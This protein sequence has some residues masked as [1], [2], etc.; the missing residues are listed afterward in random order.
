M[1]RKGGKAIAHLQVLSRG[2]PPA[3]IGRQFLLRFRQRPQ[4]VKGER[5]ESSGIRILKWNGL[6]RGGPF[7]Q[8]RTEP[9]LTVRNTSESAKYG[10]TWRGDRS[11][12]RRL[13]G[14]FRSQ[15]AL[16]TRRRDW[17]RP[18]KD[19]RPRRIWFSCC[20]RNRMNSAKFVAGISGWIASAYGLVPT[21]VTKIITRS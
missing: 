7:E 19:L 14:R 10:G 4:A 2:T 11:S 6:D 13:S 16:G 12:V 21:M 18:P 5:F 17:L 3:R 20:E 9:S 8:S 15:R 1:T